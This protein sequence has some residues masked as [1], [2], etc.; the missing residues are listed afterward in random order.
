MDESTFLPWSTQSGS[1]GR[2]VST[3]INSNWVFCA[4]GAQMKSGEALG[5]CL[6]GN[7]HGEEHQEVS[8][9]QGGKRGYCVLAAGAP[10]AK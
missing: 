3:L 7:D 8:I 6:Q 9:L 5:G 10:G 2:C 4:V 1:R